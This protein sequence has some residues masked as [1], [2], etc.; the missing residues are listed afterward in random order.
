MPVLPTSGDHRRGFEEAH[1]MQ[2]P[3]LAS[4]PMRLARMWEGF[5]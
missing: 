4:A 5:S 2:A 3:E 1:S